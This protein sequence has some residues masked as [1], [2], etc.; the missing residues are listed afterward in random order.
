MGRGKDCKNTAEMTGKGFILK[1]KIIVLSGG[2]GNQMFQY[3]FGRMLQL[4]FG[5]EV[6]FDT[7]FYDNN[8]DWK[9]GLG[10]FNIVPC[11]FNSHKI[12][13]AIRLK[14]QRI[15]VLRWIFGVYKEYRLFDIDKKV[16][17]IKYSIYAGY[18]QNKGYY[19]KIRDDLKKE[20]KIKEEL[21]ERQQELANRL[22]CNNSVAI[23]VRRGD[24]TNSKF[25]KRFVN[26]DMDY[27]KKAI[28][29]AVSILSM[30]NADNISFYCFSN[31]IAWCRNN[32]S[33][34][35]NVTYVDNS[36][37]SGPEMDM[38]L[39]ELA[40]VKIIAN[41]TFS[42]WAAWLSDRKDDTVIAPSAWYHDK[43]MNAKACTALLEKNWVII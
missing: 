18:W 34:L 32:F 29:K 21:S 11:V 27:Y 24:Y 23:H 43:K 41:S 25:N 2:L 35:K 5:V 17:H 33:D 9:M 8:T 7:C 10:K 1:R 13:N 39:I 42:W 37:S 30:T 31:D 6:E 28:D 3:A 20:F 26:L 22:K 4:R 14:I 19:E 36:I 15:Y 40:K 16:F 12:Y 38:S